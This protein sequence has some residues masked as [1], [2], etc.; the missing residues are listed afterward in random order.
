ME[1]YSTIMKDEKHKISVYN[2]I[3]INTNTIIKLRCVEKNLLFFE[4]TSLRI[5][6]KKINNNFFFFNMYTF[7]I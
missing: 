7:L 5:S 6:T 2:Y 1:Y 3:E 4:K